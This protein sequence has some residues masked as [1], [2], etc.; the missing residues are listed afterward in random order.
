VLSRLKN[1][2]LGTLRRQ[3][4]V[5]M[6]V[7]MATTV[8]LFVHDL[9]RREQVHVM[10]QQSRQA[11]A[12][13]QGVARAAAI[14]LASR[15][16]AGLQEIVDGLHGYPDLSHAIVLDP[17]GLVLAHNDV[18]RRG[19]YL[20][21]LPREAKTTVVQRTARLVDVASPVMLGDKSIGW[22]RIG[23]G[24]ASLA[25]EIAAVRQHGFGYA[26]L[27]V[28]LSVAFAAFA[29]RV[30]SRRLDAIQQVANA[31][32][33]GDTGMRVRLH[34]DD[35]AARLG[36]QFN[37]MLDRIASERQA[38]SDSE[39][40]FRMSVETSPLPM[41]WAGPLPENRILLMNRQFTEVFGYTPKDIWDIASWW[42]RA[43]PDP[44][45]RQEV[46][47][48][49]GAAIDAMLASGTNHTQPVGATITCKDGTTRFVDVRMAIEGDRSLVVFSDLTE[50]RAYELELQAHRH[51]L[52]TLVEERTVALSIAKELAETANRAKS[53]FLANMS[54]ELRTPM[55]AIMGMTDLALRHTEDPKLQDQLGKVMQASKHLLHVINDILDISKI[56][57]ERMTLE[58]TDFRLGHV[59]ENLISLISHKA[60]EKGLQLQVDLTP[61]VAHL[62]LQGD[63]LRLGQ[64]LLN[65]VG[66]AVKFT[67][68][69]AIT[70]RARLTEEGPSDVLLR[71]EVIDTGIGIS[72]EDQKRLF[73]AF[74]QADGSMTRKYGGTGLGLA[75]SKRLARLMGGEIGVESQPG[76]GS[77][78]W[79]TV[80][81][82]KATHDAVP[83]APTFAA[84]SADERLLDQYAG[85][86]ILLAEDEPINQEVSRGLLEDAGLVVDLAEDGQHA[87]ALARR[88]RYALILMD[89]QMPNLNGIDATKAIRA[90][91]GYADTP[92]LAMTANAF[93]EDRQAC[94]DAGMNDHIAKP[95]DPQVLFETL[96]KWLGT[97]PTQ[98]KEAQ[99]ASNA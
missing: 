5:G 36:R 16:F 62:T 26:L 41:L 67:A 15:D 60:Q 46:Q 68:T 20:S 84:Q 56:E 33:S 34:G 69:G 45:Y 85:K 50:R 35:E 53:Q 38:L 2:L 6:A 59:L 8:L 11:Q 98:S 32:Q 47:A 91:P 23:L 93:N 27:A 3:L 19:L 55:N 81:L 70:L 86:R 39:A 13:A 25:A 90:L 54:H 96:L 74:E 10:E 87:V 49:W 37:A 61:D 75:I 63:S 57:A 52:E 4:I 28:V 89:M 1:W 95:V 44:T 22:V 51:H 92:I 9:T 14:W 43:Y 77:T 58:K 83:S 48:Q 94:L 88:N 12:L 72:P 24:G 82:D 78:F 73:T 42:P 79:F 76:Q 17:Q 30:F 66:N 40:R 29:G 7:L 65:L 97:S 71:C 99:G 64:I 31:V 80:R 21:D 18:E